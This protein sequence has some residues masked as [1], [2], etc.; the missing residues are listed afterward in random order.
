MKN[1][2][3]VVALLALMLGACSKPDDKKLLPDS[4][5]T[6]AELLR[7]ASTDSNAYYGLD[8]VPADYL[9]TPLA[10][11]YVPNSMH[12]LNHVREL[13]RDFH[14]VPNPRIT[15]YVYPHL[16]DGEIPV[17]G[18]FTVFDLYERNHYALE[19]EGHHVNH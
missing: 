19:Q 13:D 9:G 14:K 15:A 6:T 1:Y 11:D 17:P 18:Y 12:S 3:L 16:N 10:A 5:A 8:A 2:S 4:G 7:G